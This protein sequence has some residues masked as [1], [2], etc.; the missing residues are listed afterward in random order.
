MA[1]SNGGRVLA[2]L[3]SR[4]NLTGCVCGLAG[5]ALALTGLAGTYWPV[6]VAGLYGAGA[7]I[8]PPD[9]PATPRFATPEE[10][11]EAELDA[12][13]EDFAALR[14]YLKTAGVPGEA[15]RPLAELD[16]LL[17]AV[18]EPGLVSREIG[19]DPEAVHVLGRAVRRDVPE[20]VDAYLRTRWWSRLNPGSEPSERHLERQLGLLTR[21]IEAIATAAREAQEHRQRIITRELEDRGAT[22][23]NWTDPGGPPTP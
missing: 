8:A 3:E 9:R 23:P 5:L 17:A 16:R 12:L 1:T 13:R 20:A 7:L 21:E 18:L 11:A 19:V 4:K 14:A 15:G 22:G 10:Q 6:V 2:Y